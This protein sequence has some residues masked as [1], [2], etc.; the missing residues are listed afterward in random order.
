[1]ALCGPA[2]HSSREAYEK[3]DR[4][5]RKS[6]NE[7][8]MGC[9][10]SQGSGDDDT[11]VSCSVAVPP[12]MGRLDTAEVGHHSD[13]DRVRDGWARTASLNPDS[14]ACSLMSDQNQIG[15][16]RANKNHDKAVEAE[17][18]KLGSSKQ[19]NWNVNCCLL[20]TKL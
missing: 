15:Q 8:P 18:D 20:F 7:N 10:S 1:M 13:S 17:N 6:L 11:D 14:D 3:T 9:Q 16:G 12:I 2:A 19:S 4:V 5:A